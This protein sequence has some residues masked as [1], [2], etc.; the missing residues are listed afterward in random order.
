MRVKRQRIQDQEIITR[1]LY[2]C[3]NSQQYDPETVL[4]DCQFGPT[5]EAPDGK[6]IIAAAREAFKVSTIAKIPK[7]PSF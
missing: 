7:L 4:L 5:E 3:R 1:H 6:A 2:I